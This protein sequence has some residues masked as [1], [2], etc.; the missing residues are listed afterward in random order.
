MLKHKEKLNK[1][2]VKIIALISF[3]IGFSQ[4]VSMYILS[5]F[6]EKIVGASMVGYFYAGAYAV[7]LIILLNL[8]KLVRKFGRYS[9]FSLAC[10]FEILALSALIFFGISNL[11]AYLAASFIIFS[12]LS[13]VVLDIIL[14]ANSKDEFSGRIRG[15]Y[16]TIYN[17]G[18][19]FG[20]FVSTRVLNKFD[21]NGIFILVF[22]LVVLILIIFLSTVGQVKHFHQ[23]RLKVIDL[24]RH[25]WKKKNIIRIYYVSFILEVFYALTIIY[26][27]I[28]LREIVGLSWSEIGTAFTF[29]LI[30]FV[31]LQYPVGV[32]ADKKYGEKEFLFFSLTVMVISTGVIYFFVSESIFYWSIILFT[33]RIGAAMIEILRDSYFYK[34]IDGDDVDLIDFFR[35]AMPVGY[36]FAAILSSILLIFFPIKIVFLVIVI[37]AISGFYPVFRLKDSR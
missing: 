1:H 29:M 32:L 33:T 30:P 10:L 28:Y 2:R 15:M 21:F 23:K 37:V 17:F 6:F 35:T 26:M 11:S 36:I 27:P 18:L 9:V 5:T 3:F 31:L 22:I 20:P 14:E 8:H 4:A 7:F 24:L 13:F 19:L 34:Q 12:M 25:A 16:L